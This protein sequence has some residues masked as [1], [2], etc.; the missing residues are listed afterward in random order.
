MGP[1]FRQLGQEHIAQLVE[2][3]DVSE[4]EAF[5]RR[6]GV[7]ASLRQ[8]RSWRDANLAQQGC[9]VGEGLV[10]DDW[11]QAG[12]QKVVLVGAERQP[13]PFKNQTTEGLDIIGRGDAHLAISRSQFEICE[14]GRIASARP[15]LAAVPGI[16]Q[17]ALVA[18]S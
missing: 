3:R 4:E 5:V 11:F 6:H 13:G 10:S 7:D 9:E 16:P 18:S 1:G 17:T 8:W 14:A 15:V 12:P 2:G